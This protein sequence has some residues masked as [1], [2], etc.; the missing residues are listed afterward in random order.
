M[1]RGRYQRISISVFDLYAVLH[2]RGLRFRR[3]RLVYPSTRLFCGCAWPS[4]LWPSRVK[5][6]AEQ[7]EWAL[8]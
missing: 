2:P 3:V 6:E 4:T 7:D 5:R 8:R 1:Q